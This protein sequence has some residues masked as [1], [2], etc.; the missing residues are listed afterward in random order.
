MPNLENM[1]DLD[2]DFCNRLLSA[3]HRYILKVT[4]GNVEEE[5][6][7]CS[8]DCLGKWTK[9]YT[10][11]QRRAAT[12]RLEHTIAGETEEEPDEEQSLEEEIEEHEE[13]ELRGDE[14]QQRYTVPADESEAG[15]EAQ[16]KED[17]EY[18]ELSDL[19]KLAPPPYAPKPKLT[20]IYD[21]IE[22][23]E[24]TEKAKRER[25]QKAE[26][27]KAVKQQEYEESE[28]KS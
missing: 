4:H 20:P 17:G 21:F 11:E 15:E 2:C 5:F 14:E 24:P 19:Q 26:K 16:Y 9:Q 3:E 7:F 18:I 22:E 12:V 10:E 8:L 13:E 1:P 23:M 27:E 6:D 28:S 25:E